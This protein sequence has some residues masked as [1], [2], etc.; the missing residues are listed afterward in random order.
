MKKQ[1]HIHYSRKYLLQT[2]KHTNKQTNKHTNKHTNKQTNKQIFQTFSII[3]DEKSPVGRLFSSRTGYHQNTRVYLNYKYVG[4][5]WSNAWINFCEALIIIT[6]DKG[7]EWYCFQTCC[8]YVYLFVGM[9]V[10]LSVRS[11]WP[12]RSWARFTIF[13]EQ[14]NGNPRRSN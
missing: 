5:T 4:V 1:L 10:C 2:N 9:F 8:G 6:R 14:V 3:L 7:E 12:W 13:G 11:F